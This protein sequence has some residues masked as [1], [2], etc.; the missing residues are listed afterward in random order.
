MNELPKSFEIN[1]FAVL[2]GVVPDQE[3]MAIERNLAGLSI[4]KAGTRNVLIN[5]WCA[6]L[7]QSLKRQALISSCLPENAVA[8]QC[9]YF[10]K[11][12][13]QNWLVALHRDCSIPVKS[14]FKAPG[15]SQWSEKEG[16]SYV[17]PPENV[18]ESLVAIR[19]H[20]EDNSE[21]N[22]PLQVVPG[23]HNTCESSGARTKCLVRKGG[24]VLMRPLLLHASSK[25]LEGSRRVLHF[26]YGPQR[27]PDG[28]EWAYAV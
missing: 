17:R 4:D 7:A 15:W 14:Q 16:I 27:L 18:L 12:H 19:V 9:T 5:E 8:V 25:L 2:D 23:S 11:S 24:I 21:K 26:I 10:E 13:A 6:Q 22:A 20:L 3:I 1:G 28:A